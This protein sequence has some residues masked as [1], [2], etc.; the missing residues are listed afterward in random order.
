MSVAVTWKVRSRYNACKSLVAKSGLGPCFSERTK[1]ISGKHHYL[2]GFGPAKISSISG[3]YTYFLIRE[4]RR[5]NG[6][7]QIVAFH[8]SLSKGS[9]APSFTAG[10]YLLGNVS[11]VSVGDRSKSFK[12]VWRQLEASALSNSSE[13]DLEMPVVDVST[14]SIGERF[15]MISDLVR[16]VVQGTVNSLI[17][18]GNGG[19]GKT[20]TIME[21][22]SSLGYVEDEDYIK[23][24]GK[25]TPGGLFDVLAENSDRV[26][27]F[28]D[29]DS[30]LQGADAGNFLK[31]AL[32]TSRRRIVTYLSMT[33]PPRS[34]V[35]TGKII[36]ISNL[37]PSKLA[38]ALKSRSILL[39]LMMTNLEIV[40]RMRM[41]LD[42]VAEE[43]D[44]CFEH[45]KDA[46][47]TIEDFVNANPNRDMELSLR[48]LVKI[49]N[50][51]KSANDNGK[52]KR[53]AQYA[54]LAS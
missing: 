45:A 53:I 10:K 4:D 46:V 33:Q 21:E 38:S 29:C 50:V 13:N 20:R 15:D 31:A 18:T 47:D 27:V 8:N 37:D 11:M 35:F 39:S 40:E 51:R 42:S 1:K 44:V 2:M 6:H 28:D 16:M 19:M 48:T 14:F 9:E 32:D 7:G 23:I 3:T 22:F 30:V 54:L 12:S 26:I 24:S 34:I 36:I 43:N 49:M 5:E 25:V 41:I 17:L 52:W